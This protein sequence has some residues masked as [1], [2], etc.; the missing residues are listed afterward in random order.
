VATSSTAS[1]KKEVRKREELAS[2][3]PHPRGSSDDAPDACD[4][5]RLRWNDDLALGA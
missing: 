3:R 1:K 2:R 5:R 4:E